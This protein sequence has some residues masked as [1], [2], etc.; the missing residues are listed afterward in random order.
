MLDYFLTEGYVGINENDD[1][2]RFSSCPDILKF[3][4]NPDGK[5]VFYTESINRIKK[6]RVDDI[7]IE[8]LYIKD[9]EQWEEVNKIQSLS[10]FHHK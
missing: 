7:Y 1:I 4:E 6:G 5:I 3:E 10:K 9:I 8:K 2:E